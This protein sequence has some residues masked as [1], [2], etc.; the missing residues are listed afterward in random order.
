MKTIFR[1]AIFGLLLGA[2]FAGGALATFAQDKCTEPR[3]EELD[4]AI[5]ANVGTGTVDAWKK[6]V[7]AGKEYLEKYGHC[8]DNVEFVDYV[9]KVVPAF[10]KKISDK[11]TNDKISGLTKKFFDG[12][13]SKNWDDVYSSG[14]ELMKIDENRFRPAELV[15]GSIGLDET[16]KTPKNTKWNDQ[17]L[18]WAKQSISDLQGGKAFSVTNNGKTTDQFGFNPFAYKNKADAIGW[19]NYTIGYITAMDK[20]DKKAGASYLYKASQA[21]SDTASNPEVYRTIGSYYIDEYSKLADELKTLAN[22]P[23]PD[24]ATDEEKAA[25]LEQLKNKKAEVNG[26]AERALEAY[27]KA[28]NAAKK[29]PKS[30]EFAKQLTE[31]AKEIYGARHPDGKGFDAYMA[32]SGAKPLSDPATPIAPIPDPEPA[33][34]AKPAGT[35]AAAAAQ[36]DAAAKTAADAAKPAVTKPKQ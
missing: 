8:T 7:D 23:L 12:I 2:I 28:A 17:T 10:E 31:K 6:T 24:T 34:S 35:A 29:D 14:E 27:A 36:P 1:S 19:M 11:E 9:K 33:D 22:T 3:R 25:R 13:S 5:R 4:S 21:A 30:A 18:K 32:G 20:G 15:M 26:A 16:A